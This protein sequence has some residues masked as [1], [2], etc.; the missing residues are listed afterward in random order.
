VGVWFV[1][2]TISGWILFKARPLL[3]SGDQ[4]LTSHE[5]NKKPLFGVF[6]PS[7]AFHSG[8]NRLSMQDGNDSPFGT[9]AIILM[10]VFKEGRFKA[11]QAGCFNFSCHI[12]KFE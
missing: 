11:K 8:Q 1:I 9:L 12:S 5:A 10:P 4:A 6:T 2:D 3:S 7:V